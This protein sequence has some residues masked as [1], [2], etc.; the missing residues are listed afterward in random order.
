MDLLNNF[1]LMDSR[2]NEILKSNDLCDIF[3]DYFISDQ[4]NSFEISLSK[5]VDVYL[6][7]LRPVYLSEML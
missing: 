1:V 7:L 2:R 4:L 5:S 6:N 3:V